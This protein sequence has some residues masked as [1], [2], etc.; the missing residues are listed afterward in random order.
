MFEYLIAY[1][2]LVT[3]VGQNVLINSFTVC[4]F[5]VFYCASRCNYY[6]YLLLLPF[7]SFRFVL[8]C[9]CKLFSLSSYYIILCCFVLCCF[10]LSAI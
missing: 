6:D 8:L 1:T 9:V 5:L 3:V 10:V 7:V 4:L 2:P